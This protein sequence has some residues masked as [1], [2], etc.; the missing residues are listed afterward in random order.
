MRRPDTELQEEDATEAPGFPPPERKVITQPYDLSISTLLEQWDQDLLVLPDMQREYVWDRG[1]A[2]RLIESLILNI[3]IPVLY[4]SETPDA[5][6][7][8]IDGHQ[9]ISSVVQFLKNEFALTGLRVLSEYRGKRFHELPEREQRFIRSRTMRAVVV[10][11]ESHPNMKFEIFERL[12]T[13][14]IALN[15]QEL[16][17]SLFRGSFNL[18]LKQLVRSPAFRACIGTRKPRRRMVDEELILRFFALSDVGR[19]LPDPA[20]QKSTD[21]GVAAYRPPLKTFLNTFM[22]R[23]QDAPSDDIEEMRSDFALS[24]ERIESTLGSAAFRPIDQDGKPLERIVSRAFF[25]AQSLAFLWLDEDPEPAMAKTV[26]ADLS[27]D[28]EFT[29]SIRRATSDRSRLLLRVN[30]VVEAFRAVGLGVSP[31]PIPPV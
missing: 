22:Q 18:L 8:I 5:R 25:D 6:Y 10:T 31:P 21:Y 2:S 17:N 26:L 4:F 20:S 11:A 14:S 12:N 23:V 7:E 24:I 9:R 27:S 13:G 3:P 28:P 30:A 15:E 16:R 1:R 19:C 29:D